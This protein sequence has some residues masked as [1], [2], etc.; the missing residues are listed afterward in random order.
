MQSKNKRAPTVAE[1]SYIALIKSMDCGCCGQT[2]P[3]EA[4]EIDQGQ[5]FTSIPL[6]AD[7]HRGG[8]NGIHG[9]RRIWAVLKKTELSVL[10]ETIERVVAL[11]VARSGARALI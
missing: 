2:G 6:C 1:R 11:L 5:W 7:C 3:S 10:N 8:H 9:Q 4:H